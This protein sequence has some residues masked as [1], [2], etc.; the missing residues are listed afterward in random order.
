M[1]TRLV[2]IRF[3]ENKNPLLL[4]SPPNE[5]ALNPTYEPHTDEVEIQKAI[6]KA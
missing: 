6:G 3:K 5:L 1:G 2:Q 4:E